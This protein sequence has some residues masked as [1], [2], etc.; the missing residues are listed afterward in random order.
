MLLAGEIS[1][2]ISSVKRSGG[3]GDSQ[4]FV[5]GFVG[6]A[7]TGWPSISTETSFRCSPFSTS[8]PAPMPHDLRLRTNPRG[9]RIQN[10]IQRDFGNPVIGRAVIFEGNGARFFGAH[11]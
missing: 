5:V 10:E 7:A 1:V 6:I 3:S 4:L 2:T 11:G 9:L 8:G